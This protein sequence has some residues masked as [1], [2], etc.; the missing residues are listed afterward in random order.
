MKNQIQLNQFYINVQIK[1]FQ[2]I[3]FI[4][5]FNKICGENVNS[6]TISESNE[7][8][9]DLNLNSTKTRFGIFTDYCGPGNWA[10]SNGAVS[11]GFFEDIDHCC[12][13]HDECPNV[14]TQIGDYH[15]Y[16]GLDFM[17]QEFSK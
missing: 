9:E 6:T 12:K 8:L 7:T 11:P 15:K 13:S 10:D 16:P 5:L 4:V 14:I 3:L 2:L 17:S 1:M